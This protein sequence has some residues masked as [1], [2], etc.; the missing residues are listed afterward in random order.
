MRKSAKAGAREQFQIVT[1]ASRWFK[2]ACPPSHTASS[3]LL[4]HL[5]PFELAIS[6]AQRSQKFTARGVFA[7]QG[8]VQSRLKLRLFSRAF[9]RFSRFQ[10]VLGPKDSLQQI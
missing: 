6:R 8:S 5:C 4:Q 2:A 9:F 7:G 10:V 3:G 1:V